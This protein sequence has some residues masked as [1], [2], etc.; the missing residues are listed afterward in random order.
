MEKCKQCGKIS[1]SL[2]NGL[3]KKCSS[4]TKSKIN[5]CTRCNKITAHNINGLCIKCA[6]RNMNAEEIIKKIHTSLKL[7]DPRKI[8]DLVKIN[9]KKIIAIA[10]KLGLKGF[11]K[12]RCSKCGKYIEAI[13]LCNDCSKLYNTLKSANHVQN[14][15]KI[16]N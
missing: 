12:H 14:L 11:Y 13:G 1:Y 3:C 9:E 6:T 10:E 7:N 2:T 15:R 4:T 8:R 5:K 16:S